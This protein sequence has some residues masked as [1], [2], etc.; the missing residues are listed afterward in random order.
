[1]ES[2]TSYVKGRGGGRDG[3]PDRQW[4]AQVAVTALI[5]IRSG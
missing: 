5:A 4:W 3:V 1:M 2:T